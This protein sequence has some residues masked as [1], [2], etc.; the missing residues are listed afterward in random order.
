VAAEQLTELAYAKINLT[1]RIRGRRSDGYHELESIVAF[2]DLADALTL[3][4]GSALSLDISGPLAGHAGPSESNLVIKAA[5]A[6]T[7]RVGGLTTGHF[8]LDKK[9][10]AGAGLGGGSADAAAAL[11]LL[12]KANG[13]PLDDER[14]ITAA[15][16]VGADVPVCLFGEARLMTGIGDVLS[17][18]YFMPRLGAVL[19]FPGKGL[20]TKD[21]YAA[22]DA[23][24][25]FNRG[26]VPRSK[27]LRAAEL[28]DLE[29][30]AV[31]M[32]PVVG[33]CLDA[34]RVSGAGIAG[35]SGSGSAC[36]G[37]YETEA[38]A[39]R[40]AG[41]LAAAHPDWWVRPTVLRASSAEIPAVTSADPAQVL[42]FM[43]ELLSES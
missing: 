33:V 36:F 43:R 39:Q 8:T 4:P 23:L 32:A 11:R 10:P 1:L 17:G 12:A 29:Q 5:R 6:L 3:S 30:A 42:R 25:Q 38:T 26:F 19:A 14:V 20:A 31:S 35:M 7:E 27:E 22:H 28:N 15:R 34:M 21:V 18:P 9:V 13:L 40:A 41:M 2:V 24:D 16:V 37:L